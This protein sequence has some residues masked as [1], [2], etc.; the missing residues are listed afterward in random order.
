MPGFHFGF[1]QIPLFPDRTGL[2]GCLPQNTLSIH[3][4]KEPYY[5]KTNVSRADAMHRPNLVCPKSKE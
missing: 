1:Q 3:L 5:E 2:N 4:T